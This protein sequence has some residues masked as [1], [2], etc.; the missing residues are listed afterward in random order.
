MYYI[1][2]S[3]DREVFPSAQRS[4]ICIRDEW[5]S[6]LTRSNAGI[7][8]FEIEKVGTFVEGRPLVRLFAK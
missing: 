5:E 7:L 1:Y 4:L 2:Y 3:D 8:L 6:I